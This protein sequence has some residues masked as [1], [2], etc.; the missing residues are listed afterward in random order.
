MATAQSPQRRTTASY[1]LPAAVLINQDGE[2]LKLDRLLASDKII[3]LNFI[4]ASCATV[5]PVL[6]AGFANFQDKLDPA[7]QQVQLVSVTIDPEHDTPE[8]LRE[9]SQRFGADPGWEFLTGSRS[10]INAVM[11]A[12]DAFVANKMNHRPLTFVHKP[13]ADEWTRI[14]GFLSTVDYLGVYTT[15]AEE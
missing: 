13:G 14:E 11:R 10:D 3:M 4:F 5:C 2:Q 6:T 8:V 9:Y 15:L 7:T 12:F 1:K